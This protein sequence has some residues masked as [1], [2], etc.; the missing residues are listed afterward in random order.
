M[1]PLSLSSLG[2]RLAAVVVLV[3]LN[4][5]FVMAEFALVGAR[6]SKLAAMAEAGD[7]GA[8][9]AQRALADLDRYISGTQLGITLASLA[10]G[11]IGEPALAVV[12]DRLLAQFGI[13]VPPGMAHTAAGTITAFAIIT[14]LHIVLGELA[15]KS[16]ALVMPERI[17]GLVALPLMA[18]SKVMSPFIWVLNGA[19]NWL[20]RLAG[21]RPMSEAHH[22]HSPEEIRLLVMQARAV[23]TLNETDSAMLAGIFDFAAKRVHDV[24]RPR[25]E[26]VALHV[27]ADEQ[28]IA[29]IVRRER[30]SR[31]PVY[32]E[33]LDDIVGVFLSKDLWL[34]EPGRPF[35]LREHLRDPLLIPASRSAERVLDDLRR[36]RAQMAVVLDEFGGT[37]GIITMEDL[38]EE[39]IG[40][41]ADEYDMASRD[42]VEVDGVLELSG[43]LS[44]VDVRSDHRLPIPEGEWTTLG[45]YVFARLGHVPKLGERA[46]YPGGELEV[47]AMDK[48][49]V[50]AVRV[51]RTPTP[52]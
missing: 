14:F 39:V 25:T 42:V 24:M 27:D 18:F 22:A 6:R 23:G 5:F 19:A 37:A 26:I 47:M 30:Y 43:S 49:R 4:G 7:R 8:R 50:A 3:L 9:R 32:D 16:V 20:L 11:W 38:I 48:R 33:S 31:Y 1:E 45:G 15:P 46:S 10:L 2:S 52:R 35:V 51:H 44:L 13:D 41:I 40:D 21:I 12:V 34:R 36:T 17:S 29:T 28:E